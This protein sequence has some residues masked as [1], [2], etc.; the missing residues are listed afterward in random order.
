MTRKEKHPRATITR[1]N[2]PKWWDAT[3]DAAWKEKNR[4]EREFE[5]GRGTAS[6]EIFTKLRIESN[7]ATAQFKRTAARPIR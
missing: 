2:A 1:K 4:K 5:E 6:K 3:V 7:H